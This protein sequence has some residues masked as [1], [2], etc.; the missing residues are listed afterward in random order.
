M[1]ELI[2]SKNTLDHFLG[3]EVE[4]ITTIKNQPLTIV[5]KNGVNVMEWAEA[6][7]TQLNSLLLEHGAILMRGFN[8]GSAKKF[9]SLFTLLCGDPMEYSNRTSPRNRVHDNV[10]TSTS[11]AS[12]QTIHMHTENSYSMT[13]NR[14]I[15][16]F[17]LVQPTFA[18]ETPI[19]NESKLLTSL[20]KETVDKFRQKGIRYVRNT[21]PGIGLDWQ[22]IY[23]TIDKEKV[24][25]HLESLGQEYVWLDDDHL[26]V[27][28]NLPAIQR[29]PITQEEMWFN[30]MYFGHKS[31]YDSSVLEYFEEEN[32][33][34]ATYY[35]DGSEIEQDVIEEFNHFYKEQSLVFSWEKDDFLL[36]DNMMFAHGRKPY[37]GDRTILAAMGQPQKIDL[38]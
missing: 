10:Y 7:K 9:N 21:I 4:I 3:E 19:A 27:S 35:G 8:L 5:P 29:H 12:D 18:G 22:T 24:N 36:L 34:F 37:K 6:H 2:E 16:F 1:E 17:C 28:W 23:Q 30:H 15:A 20:R 13:F 14:V 26:R 31:L 32:L 33:P 38:T 11:H 25:E